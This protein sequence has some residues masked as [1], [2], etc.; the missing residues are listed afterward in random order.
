MLFLYVSLSSNLLEGDCIPIPINA[1]SFF[2]DPVLW[3][4]GIKL[5]ADFCVEVFTRHAVGVNGLK[6]TQLLLQVRL[7]SVQFY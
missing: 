2:V 3:R 4:S 1:I 7:D 5:F 6:V